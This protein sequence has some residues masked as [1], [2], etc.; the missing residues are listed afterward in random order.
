MSD[1]LRARF[2]L[3]GTST[4]YMSGKSVYNLV[5]HDRPGIIAPVELLPGDA[6][7]FEDAVRAALAD[8]WDEGF[9]AG[10]RD[11]MGHVTF[12]EPC[13]QNP[14]RAAKGEQSNG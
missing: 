12:D 3:A 13:I 7:A 4:V 10:E 6:E 1:Y 5:R 8:A 9:D 11:A 14:Y 2:P